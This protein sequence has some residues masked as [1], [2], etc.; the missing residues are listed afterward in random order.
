MVAGAAIN[1]SRT[2]PLEALLWWGVDQTRSVA[3]SE[4]RGTPII[5]HHHRNSPAPTITA[6]HP[7]RLAVHH[8]HPALM[9]LAG[10]TAARARPCGKSTT[11]RF[12]P[13]R[14]ATYRTHWVGSS[15]LPIIW[16]KL[17]SGQSNVHGIRL[18]IATCVL[19]THDPRGSSVDH[20]QYQQWAFRYMHECI[21]CQC[22]G[23]CHIANAFIAIHSAC[24]SH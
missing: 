14:S 3:H 22:P 2:R 5:Y 23:W 19:F 18:F 1:I 7:T 4:L 17:S 8:H 24:R 13:W 10:P 16:W 21:W 20:H 12:H 11:R 9:P 15:C 6:R